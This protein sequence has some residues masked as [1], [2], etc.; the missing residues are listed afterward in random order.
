MDAFTKNLANIG[1]D[2][3]QTRAEIEE[4]S[5]MNIGWA[6]NMFSLLDELQKLKN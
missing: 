5:E 6:A 1:L 2:I 4:I 3:A